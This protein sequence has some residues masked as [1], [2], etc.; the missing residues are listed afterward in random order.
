MRKYVLSLLG[1]IIICLITSYLLT[2]PAVRASYLPG[3]LN[4][5]AAAPK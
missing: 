5:G 4:S 3:A 1:V 2:A